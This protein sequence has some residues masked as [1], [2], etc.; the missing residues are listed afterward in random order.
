MYAL[1]QARLQRQRVVTPKYK[2]ILKIFDI[3]ELFQDLALNYHKWIRNRGEGGS[4]LPSRA[5][6]LYGT[7]KFGI[8]TSKRTS[9]K[10]MKM[11]EK[12]PVGHAARAEVLFFLIKCEN[13]VTSSLPS[14]SSSRKFSYIL[15]Y[16]SSFPFLIDLHL[17]D[18]QLK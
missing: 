17:L 4:L 16:P 9:N 6:V 3:Q 5:G 18:T 2:F 8:F 1:R 14:S 7:S 10:C 15:H 12:T 13:F 11:K